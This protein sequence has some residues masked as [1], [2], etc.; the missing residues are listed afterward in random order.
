LNESIFYSSNKED[1]I[2]QGGLLGAI[3]MTIIE[4]KLDG[5]CAD[6][7]QGWMTVHIFKNKTIENKIIC[8]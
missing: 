6:G 2:S 8:D 7:F 1:G 4:E 5:V 3:L